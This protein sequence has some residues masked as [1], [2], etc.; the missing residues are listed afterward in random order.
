MIF[1]IFLKDTYYNQL[2]PRLNPVRSVAAFVH[3]S[4]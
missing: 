1:G 2:S 4:H 3:N